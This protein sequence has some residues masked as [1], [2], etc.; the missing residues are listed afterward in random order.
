M[1][2][3]VYPGFEGFHIQV[4]RLSRHDALYRLAR[5]A[6]ETFNMQ[7][8]Q[9]GVIAVEYNDPDRVELNHGFQAHDQTLKHVRQLQVGTC[10]LRDLKDHLRAR[11]PRVAVRSRGAHVRSVPCSQPCM[12]QRSQMI[13]HRARR[14]FHVRGFMLC[15]SF[16][17]TVRCRDAEKRTRTSTGLLPLE[18]ESS[19]SANSAISAKRFKSMFFSS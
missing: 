9:S 18:P 13:A 12:H 3:D 19:A 8:V 5:L 7:R 6:T 16:T 10:G 2:T 1:L 14:L 15:G 17:V 4:R 11:L